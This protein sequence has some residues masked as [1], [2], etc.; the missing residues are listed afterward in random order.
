MRVLIAG[1]TWVTH[2]I[3]IEG[4]TSYSTGGYAVGL[5]ELVKAL[6]EHGHEVVHVTNHEAGERFP[7]TLD[8]LA[9]FDVVVLSDIAADTI[10][11]T[12]ACVERGERT[13]DRLRVLRDHVAAGRG[14]LMVGG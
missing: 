8:E 5:T 14:L 3:E 1:E 12:P 10:Q 6:G 11:L 2:R 4:F 9:G 7:W 13:P